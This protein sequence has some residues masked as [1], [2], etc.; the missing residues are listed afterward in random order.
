L[1]SRRLPTLIHRLT[2]LRRDEMGANLPGGPTTRVFLLGIPD[3]PDF[4]YRAA[5]LIVS[6]VVVVW[7]LTHF[8]MDQPPAGAGTWAGRLGQSVAPLFAPLGIEWRETLALLFGF[9]AKEIIIGALAVIYS[10]GDLTTRIAAQIG[11]LQA[12]SF[13]LFV[14]LYTPCIAT[15]ASIH[16]ESRSWRIT[17]LSLALGLVSAWVASLLLYQTGLA[18]VQARGG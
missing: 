3:R 9:I 2:T 14:L 15:V 5:T 13:M 16:A 4:L 6:G 8:P 10:G 12:L 1:T 11:P 17:L 18:L 7:L